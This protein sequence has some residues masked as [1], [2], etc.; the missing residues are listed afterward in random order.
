[1]TWNTSLRKAAGFTLV[2][3]AIALMIIG[4]LLGGVLKGQ[5][6][7]QSARATQFVRQINSYDTALKAFYSLYNAFPGD[8][9]NPSSK[10]PNCTTAPCSVAGNFDRML[11]TRYLTP[12][13]IPTMANAILGENR[14]FWVH[15]AK[16]NLINGIDT[17][18]V[19]GTPFSG[20]WG[21]ELPAGPVSDSGFTAEYYWHSN[22]AVFVSG[23]YYV[24]RALGDGD[25]A[26]SG[27]IG[28]YID[29]KLDDGLPEKGDIRYANTTGN[30][31]DVYCGSATGYNMVKGRTCNLVIRIKV[32]E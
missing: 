25:W 32:I 8:M 24:I 4:I 6:L 16:A 13:A 12:G 22:P 14:N 9:N 26:L 7:I 30:A 18:I 29:G 10:I 20:I 3:L 2:E 19:D 21:K 5:E 11:D 28:S 31:G 23:N 27:S 15:L 1:M 17:T